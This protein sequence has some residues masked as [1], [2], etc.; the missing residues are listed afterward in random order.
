[1]RRF[2]F[3]TCFF[4]L[5][6]ALSSCGSND[7]DPEPLPDSFVRFKVDGLQKEFK[8]SSQPMGFSFD[9]GGPVYNAIAVMNGNPADGTKN[10]VS[11]SVRNEAPFEAGK[12]YVMQT[13][14]SYGGVDM[15]RV[16][17]TYSDEQGNVYNAVLFQQTI[18]G[19]QI[20]DDAKVRFTKITDNWVEGSFDAVTMGPVTSTGLRT[21]ELRITDGVFSLPLISAIP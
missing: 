7:E 6:L 1:M 20:K 2:Y 8:L 3:Y 11:I 10:F 18:A 14:I 17:F 13:P 12:D 5:L 19:V 15:V 4:V 16:L 9:A 21:T